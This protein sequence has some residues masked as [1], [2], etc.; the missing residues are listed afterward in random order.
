MGI[1]LFH[2]NAQTDGHDE[3]NSRFSQFRERA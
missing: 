1:E 3:A 2:A